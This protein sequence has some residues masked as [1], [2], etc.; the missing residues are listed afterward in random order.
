MDNRTCKLDGC[1]RP[2]FGRGW[3]AAHWNRVRRNGDPGSPFVQD[4]RTGCLV[5]E[6]DRKHFGKGYCQVHRYRFAQHGDPLVVLQP[7][8]DA[9]PTHTAWRGD[10][11]SYNGAHKRVA[12]HRGRADQFTCTSCSQAA[13]QWAYIHGSVGEL[14]DAE[15]G[16]PYSGNVNDYTPMCVSC[17][18]RYDRARRP[19]DDWL[20][21]RTAVAAVPRLSGHALALSCPA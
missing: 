20:T 5:E 19:L 4:R 7:K 2:L 21:V 14:T 17:H 10:D 12:R 15:T 13:A 8:Q 18:I 3:C 6:C 1:E 11:V 9:G 16:N